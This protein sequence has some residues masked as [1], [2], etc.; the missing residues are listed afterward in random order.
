MNDR[1][2]FQ[3]Q[4]WSHSKKGSIYTSYT[5]IEALFFLQAA[6]MT[7]DSVSGAPHKDGSHI[8]VH[9]EITWTLAPSSRAE[10]CTNAEGDGQQF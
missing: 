10:P 9:C 5:Q 7:L 8:I 1:T 6:A 3:W 4:V 2:R